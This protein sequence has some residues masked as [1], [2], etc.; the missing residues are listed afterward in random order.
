MRVSDSTA[1]SD[2]ASLVELVHVVVADTIPVQELVS[3][4]ETVPPLI[5]ADIIP[6]SDSVRIRVMRPIVIVSKVVQLGW[7]FSYQGAWL[8]WKGAGYVVTLESSETTYTVQL[9]WS[10]SGYVVQ[11]DRSLAGYDIELLP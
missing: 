11:L 9:G 1:V 6:V 3:V 5:V 10:R 7:S 2:N 8:G 4:G